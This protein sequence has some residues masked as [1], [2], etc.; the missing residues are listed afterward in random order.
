[1]PDKQYARGLWG[2]F[3]A[4]ERPFDV[5]NGMEDNLRLIDDHLGLYTLAAPLPPETVFAGDADG[6][7]QIYEDGT[8]AVRNAGVVRQ[9]PPRK[10]LRAVLLS[11]TDSWL[12][13]GSGWEAFSVLDVTPAIE[14]AQAAVVPLVS[15]AQAANVQAQAAKD[16]AVAAAQAVGSFTTKALADAAMTG[17][18]IPLNKGVY[19][20]SDGANNG[21]WVNRTGAL[22]RESTNTLDAVAHAAKEPAATGKKNGW[23]DMFFRRSQPGVNFLGRKRWLDNG[24][25][26]AYQ[27]TVVD[28]AIF[29]V[30]KALRRTVQGSANLSG[31]L[32]YLDDIGA[33][34]GDIVTVGALI[35]GT[36]GSVLFPVSPRNSLLSGTGSQILGLTDNNVSP[37]VTSALP[38]R[39]SAEIPINDANI[40]A[41]WAYPYTISAGQSFDVVALWAYK[42][43]RTD[44]IAWPTFSEG[45]V[46]EKMIADQSASLDPLVGPVAYGFESLGAV[47]AANTTVAIAGTNFGAAPRDLPFRGWGE[48]FTPASVSFNA[49]RIKM[50]SRTPGVAT[51]SRWRTIRAVVRTGATPEG[52]NAPVVAVGSIVV[53]QTADTLTDATILLKDPTTG[54]VKTL[55]DSSF[56]EGKYFIGIYAE[57]AAGAPAACGEPR[58]TLPNSA[59]QS[60]YSTAANPVS[61][62]WFVYTSNLRIGFQHLLL[63][64]P[65]EST[66]Y[67]PSEALKQ[68]LAAP[69]DPTIPAPEIVLPPNLYFLQ[70]REGSVYLDNLHL[71]DA[72]DYLHDLSSPSSIGQQL[73]ERFSLT[74]TA[75]LASGAF[76][77]AVADKRTGTTLVMK[78]AQ[79]RVAATSAGAGSTLKVMVIG[80]SLVNA[81]VITQT[82]IDLSALDAMGLTL[83]GTRGSGAN[84]HEGR[85][86]Y[87]TNDYTTAGRTYRGF[88]VT[89]VTAAPAINSS[90][91][92]D[93][94]T[95]WTVQ[96]YSLS[97]GTGTFS[98]SVDSGPN[99]PAASG[100]LTKANGSSGDASVTFTATAPVSGNPFWIGGVVDFPQFLAN[101]GFP[102]MDWVFVALGIN[103]VFAQVSDA[104]AS[105]LADS[106][107]TQL[108]TLIAS[109]KASG[110]ST[111]VALVLPSP[112]AAMQD[113]FGANYA[114]G[115]TRWRFKRN[116]LIWARQLIARYAGQEASRIYLVP[117]NVALDT[118]NNMTRAVRS[119]VN[120]QESL[121]FT[122]TDLLFSELPQAGAVYSQ[123]FGGVV[124]NWTVT[125]AQSYVNRPAQTI[126]LNSPDQAR[127]VTLPD[128]YA[129]RV[130]MT[131]STQGAV[132]RETGQLT[133]VSGTGAATLGYTGIAGGVR[134]QDNGV[135]PGPTGYAQIGAAWWSFLKFYA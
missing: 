31:P 132:L 101:N 17:G 38:Q 123:N 49:I 120:A 51:T 62:D 83:Y 121:T 100:T 102:S 122:F 58:G 63:T 37:L 113:A 134:R 23:L 16:G 8:Y 76:S 60:Y 70:G 21:F 4:S 86:G 117:S 130:D 5:P 91:Y 18:A 92:T 119:P 29:P 6:D 128:L 114:T 13:T 55:D 82:L 42:G 44:G 25:T 103:D 14:A 127:N 66:V 85:G 59:G 35:V 15:A 7:G 115:Q 30:G 105:A 52:A 95:V 27:L 20:T 26:P 108:D 40:A 129:S 39:M 74:A 133:K 54:A 88:T 43:T 45:P 24:T 112:P 1:M 135:H 56:T 93:G 84:K 73:N 104:A 111:K 50:V 47:S 67:G 126:A 89:G 97:G 80:D 75:A 109:I 72:G 69:V 10:G 36:G 65:V 3:T 34:V 19:V 64:T 61:A 12:N 32:I 98:C 90:K 99:T 11:G 118:V 81:T 9:Y 46:Y 125:A 77:V 110:A 107:F 131:C 78:T 94:A 33:K 124:S 28:N 71:A 22:V 53:S 116:V 2:Q 57:N 79:V 106:S 41:I 87:T 96:E 68:A 48:V